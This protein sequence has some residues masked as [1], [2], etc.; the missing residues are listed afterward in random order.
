MALRCAAKDTLICLSLQRRPMFSINNY[1]CW[2]CHNTK[3]TAMN[4]Y[5]L[6]SRLRY[7]GSTQPRFETKITQTLKKDSNDVYCPRLEYVFK[8]MCQLD[9]IEMHLLTELVNEKMNV[10]LHPLL[11]S[12]LNQQNSLSSVSPSISEI[13]PEEIEKKHLFDVKLIS[14]DP[15]AKIKV[16]KEIRRLTELGLKQAKL[17]VESAPNVVKRDIELTEANTL[18]DELEN[19]GATVEVV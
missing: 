8:Q 1:T 4:S 13:A 12:S 3:M 5:Y 2:N 19:I 15:K 6:L 9:L 16:I 14:I 18:K 17:L 11:L 7:F 10:K